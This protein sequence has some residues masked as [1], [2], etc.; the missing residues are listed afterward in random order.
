MYA[1]AKV[2]KCPD[3]Q[4]QRITTAKV[5][6]GCTDQWMVVVDD[7]PGDSQE[8]H[9]GTVDARKACRLTKGL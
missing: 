1:T 7:S 5:E 2:L 9:C 8:L 6:D 4:W 3:Q